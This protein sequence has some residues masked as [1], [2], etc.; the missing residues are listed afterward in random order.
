MSQRRGRSLGGL[1]RADVESFRALLAGANLEL[2]VLA[3]VEA[4][5]AIARDVGVVDEHVLASLN[6]DESEAL[7][8]IEKFYGASRH[9]FTFVACMKSEPD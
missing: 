1:D 4:A 5:V 3:F 7:L 9:D 8:G 6:G 2:D